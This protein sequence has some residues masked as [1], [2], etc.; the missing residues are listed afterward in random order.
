M[1]IANSIRPAKSTFLVAAIGQTM[2]ALLG[3]ATA[4]IGILMLAGSANAAP[5]VLNPAQFAGAAAGGSVVVENF[6]GYLG[7]QPN[8]FTFANGRASSS[9]TPVVLTGFGPTRRLSFQNIDP[10]RTFD[11][12]P[13]GT[14][15]VGFDI[16][17][18]S[19]S[20]A[21]N[22]TVVGGS[23]TLSLFGQTGA[24]LGTFLGFQDSLG[25]SSISIVNL[26]T[27]NGFGNYSID[28]FQTVALDSVPEPATLAVWSIVGL[29]GCGY[30][31][32]RSRPR[33]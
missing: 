31:L 5:I 28:N 22:I 21:F 19:N 2:K 7:I 29:F 13:T 14:T 23:G 24:S 10:L 8:P 15:L 6:E 18:I 16:F 20:N 11:L 3:F 33:G 27:G 4:A 32:R 9:T 12:F 26:G 25:I 1:G 30:R 17:Y